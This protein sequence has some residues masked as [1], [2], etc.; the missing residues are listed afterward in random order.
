MLNDIIHILV[1]SS[2]EVDQHRTVLHRFGKLHTERN[3]MRTFDG[4]DDT[5]QTGELVE[6]VNCFIVIDDIIFYS[7]D[8]LKECCETEYRGETARK[9]DTINTIA[10]NAVRSDRRSNQTL[11]RKDVQYHGSKY[12]C[13][14]C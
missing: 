5:F 14:A 4:G 9:S 1:A 3:C 10:L 12:P 11:F 6:C 2:R 13:F 7:T 8:L